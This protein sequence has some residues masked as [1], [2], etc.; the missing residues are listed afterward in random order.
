ML[1]AEKNFDMRGNCCRLRGAF[2]CHQRTQ[3]FENLPLSVIEETEFYRCFDM[4]VSGASAMAAPM[5]KKLPLATLS[6]SI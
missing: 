6:V 2:T 4:H 5:V 1:H 3:Q